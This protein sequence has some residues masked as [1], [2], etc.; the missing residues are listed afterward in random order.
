MT[1]KESK[2]REAIQLLKQRPFEFVDHGR[3]QGALP[4]NFHPKLGDADW[5]M[6]MS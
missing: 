1:T 4:E 5:G 2:I 6:A 3:H